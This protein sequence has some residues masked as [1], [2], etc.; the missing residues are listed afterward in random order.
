MKK[1]TSLERVKMM[2]A[3]ETADRVPRDYLA[4][5]EIDKR[6]KAHFGLALNDTEGLMTR[7][8]VD[9]R[10]IRLPYTG[11]K[12]H[13]DIPGKHI[14]IWG[15]RTR[16]V[17]HGTGGYWDY[18][19]FPLKEADLEMVEAWPMPNPD[20]FDYDGIAAQCE[21]W[22]DLFKW[23]GNPGLGDVIN[24]TGMIRSMDQVLM[25]MILDEPVFIRL[26]ERRIDVQLAVTERALEKANGK[27]DGIWLGEDLG[28]QIGPMISLDLYR[29][30]LQPYHQKFVDLA[31]AYNLPVMIHSCGS[32]SWA[33]NDFI[34]MGIEV[35]DTL[36]PEAKDMA[37]AYLKETYGD[38]LAFHG[39]ISTAGPV[40][41]GTVAETIADARQILEIM[42]PGGGYAF[43]PTHMLQDNS[44]TENVIALYET[45][46][47]YGNY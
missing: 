23:Y 46:E 5:P 21:K 34:E 1:I 14:D 38:K 15:I 35:V 6:V 43:S 28:T 4:N 22:S 39:S 20:D 3:H 40:A 45:V 10:E 9:F 37:P 44:P 8:G 31:K 26:V 32:S 29:K 19:D 27:I 41:S 17:E 30:H 36:Q 2:I 47:K 24:T 18:C 33:F 42:M 13:E 16:W 12:L 25:D 7:L 11:P